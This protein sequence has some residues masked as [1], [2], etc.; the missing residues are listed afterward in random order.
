MLGFAYYLLKITIC[1]AVLFG[2]YWFFLRNKVFHAY[3]RFYLLTILVLALT[4]PLFQINIFQSQGQ[5]KTG[6]IKMLQIVTVGDEYVDNVI[7]HAPAASSFSFTQLL[8]VLYILISFF[9]LVSVILMLSRIYSLL[10][11]FPQSSM[12]HIR[13]INT[14]N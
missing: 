3:N 1:S 4:L 8:P 12:E 6:V 11:R 14:D 13:F 9:F 2:Y 7:I 5:P 10:K